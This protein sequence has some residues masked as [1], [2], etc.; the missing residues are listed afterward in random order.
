L[1]NVLD[2]FHLADKFNIR[3]LQ[4]ICSD[5]IQSNIDYNNVCMV[6]KFINGFNCPRLFQY[7]IQFIDRNILK[8]L[9][10]HSFLELTEELLITIIR[11]DELEVKPNEEI[12]I[13][14]GAH[15]WVKQNAKS[16]DQYVKVGEKIFPHIRF[17]LM[18]KEDLT[19]IVEPSQIVDQELLMEAFKNH[20]VPQ[21]SNHERFTARI[22]NS[23]KKSEDS[24][25]SAASLK[26]FSK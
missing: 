6:L 16:K 24:K 10:S 5:F 23:L 19:T 11:R 2:T 26:N 21:Q 15:N 3:S 22:I 1:D 17:P 4:V 18:P 25:R 12:Q 9:T 13:F 8:V 14:Q 20:L 7:C